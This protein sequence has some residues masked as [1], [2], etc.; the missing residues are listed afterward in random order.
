MFACGSDCNDANPDVHPNIPEVCNGIDDNCRG[1]VDEGL[2]VDLYR[3][4]DSD[5]HGD[6][7]DVVLACPGT[8]GRS[9]LGNDCDDLNPA[10]QPGTVICDSEPG[11]VLVCDS[12]GAWLPN[13]C[14]LQTNEQCV[15]Q[16]NGTG[17][18]QAPA[19]AP[20]SDL[21]ADGIADAVDNCPAVHNAGQDDADDNGFGDACECGD[22]TGD[23]MVDTLDARVIQRLAVG[24]LEAADLSCAARP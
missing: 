14:D 9:P 18:C 15:T 19:A 10:V 13:F 5:G 1:G 21:D 6:P 22:V 7:T 2:L 17:I 3:D 12:I 23:G 4:L 8:P 24:K 20:V 16:P 11:S